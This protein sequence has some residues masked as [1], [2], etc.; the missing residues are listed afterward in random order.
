[1]HDLRSGPVVALKETVPLALL[2]DA[3]VFLLLETTKNEVADPGEVGFGD[4]GLLQRGEKEI[5][6]PLEREKEGRCSR[7]RPCRVRARCW[8]KGAG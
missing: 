1:V 6:Q 5:G 4:A 8:S 7:D 3:G 2:V